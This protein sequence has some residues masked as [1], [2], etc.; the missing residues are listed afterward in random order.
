MLIKISLGM[1]S[2]YKNIIEKKIWNL[3]KDNLIILRF[4]FGMFTV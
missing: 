4:E 1:L 3:R 2:V